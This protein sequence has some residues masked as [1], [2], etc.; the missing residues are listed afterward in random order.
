M[1]VALCRYKGGSEIREKKAAEYCFVKV[2]G[3]KCKWLKLKFKKGGK[4]AKR[5][6]GRPVALNGDSGSV[7]EDDF[8]CEYE[9]PR[10]GQIRNF[11]GGKKAPRFL[12]RR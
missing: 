3:E 1:L 2:A 10:R 12:G 8:S 6:N 9:E 4:G 5:K 7:Q 11:K